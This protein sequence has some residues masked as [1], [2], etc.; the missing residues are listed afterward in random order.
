VGGHQL[1]WPGTL[2]V[3]QHG[4]GDL[5]SA[6]VPRHGSSGQPMRSCMPMD[7][8]GIQAV[9]RPGLLLGCRGEYV[10]GKYSR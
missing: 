1:E 8:L 9:C 10:L 2:H 7:P 4:A 3:C 6:V 5:L